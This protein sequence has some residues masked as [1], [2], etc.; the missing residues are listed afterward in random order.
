MT[1]F[2]GYALNETLDSDLNNS[3]LKLNTAQDECTQHSGEKREEDQWACRAWYLIYCGQPGL[4]GSGL[5]PRNC[6]VGEISMAMDGSVSVRGG[7]A[8]QA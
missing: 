7:I 4:I 1:E 2:F 3:G 8:P 6:V 5:T